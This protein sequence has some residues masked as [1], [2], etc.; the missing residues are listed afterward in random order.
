MD[1]KTKA[2]AFYG[3]RFIGVLEIFFCGMTDAL[4]GAA[5]I[6]GGHVHGYGMNRSGFEDAGGWRVMESRDLG[7]V[8]TGG[9]GCGFGWDGGVRAEELAGEVGVGGV[10]S[11]VGGVVA[12]G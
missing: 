11:G 9:K 8:Q 6:A 1:F 2:A 3:C 4:S 7:C 12:T 5:A 10:D